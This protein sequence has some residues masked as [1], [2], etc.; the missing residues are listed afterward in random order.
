MS[1]LTEQLKKDNRFLIKRLKMNLKE[2]K[3]GLIGEIIY[4]AHNGTSGWFQ[5]P[6]WDL[7]TKI[8]KKDC[9]ILERMFIWD[10]ATVK[11]IELI[12]E[13]QLISRK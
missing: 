8:R 10:Y 6:R 9:L 2:Y 1:K 13:L 7:V 3:Y 4:P 5:K 12:Q 11:A